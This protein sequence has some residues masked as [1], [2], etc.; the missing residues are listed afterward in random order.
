MSLLPKGDKI[1]GK[2]AKYNIFD[3]LEKELKIENNVI[4][5]GIVT[6]DELV[7]LYN[8]A[9]LFVFPSLYEGF[10]LPPLE[11]LKCGTPAICANNSSIPEV[12][13]ELVDYFNAYN[14]DEI[15]DKIIKNINKKEKLDNKKIQEWLK[16]FD[17]NNNANIVKKELK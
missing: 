15:K 13:G 9:D 16:K 1:K 3:N 17:W 5:T 11:S 8:I 6:Q 14:I 4:H 2:L 12:C 10:G 7:D